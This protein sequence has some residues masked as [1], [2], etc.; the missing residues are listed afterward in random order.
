MED[1][2]LIGMRSMT[3]AVFVDSTTLIYP[4]DPT[5]PQ[6]QA[7]ARAWLKTLR[8]MD[9][10]VMSIQII[11]E[12]YAVVRRK[13]A[14]AQVRTG[15]RAY[16]SDYAAWATAPLDFDTVERGW[17][18]EDRYRV[19]SRDALAL[20]SAKAVGCAYFLSEDLSDRQAYDGVTVINPFRH[21]PDTVLGR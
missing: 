6:K 10:L 15:V 13:P 5:V 18:L 20:A 7:A 16:L 21:A 19:G 11:N 14:F 17:R 12:C 1:W 4:L 8:E 3:T 9:R 2:E